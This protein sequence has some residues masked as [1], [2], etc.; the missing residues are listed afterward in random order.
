MR[1]V[2]SLSFVCAS[3]LVTCV[4][5][6]GGSTGRAAV[7]YGSTGSAAVNYGSTGKVAVASYGSTGKVAVASYGSTGSAATS[8]GSTGSAA[9]RVV[10]TKTFVGKSRQKP[11]ANKRNCGCVNCDCANCGCGTTAARAQFV[12]ILN[13][14][15]VVYNVDECGNA[16][17]APIRTV[18][19]NVLATVPRAVSNMSAINKAK[20][21]NK[22][23]PNLF[24][25]EEAKLEEESNPASSPT[26]APKVSMLINLTEF[27][28]SSI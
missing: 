17:V 22:D 5:A 7:S 3:L 23:N 18:V 6:Q 11:L 9:V 10:K 20:K 13:G 25:V 19:R 28:F 12:P 15:S 26:L 24:F 2:S 8:Y 27:V 4:M 14:K 1:F 21:A 16:E